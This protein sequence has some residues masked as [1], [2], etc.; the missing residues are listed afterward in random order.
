MRVAIIEN[1]RCIL[2][3]LEILLSDS[4]CNVVIFNHPRNAIS[5][6][7]R[8][9]VDVLIRDYLMPEFTGKELLEKVK[10]Y[11]S[12]SCRIIIVSGYMEQ[13]DQ[14]LL[15]QLG[16]VAFLPKPLDLDKLCQLIE[17]ERVV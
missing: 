14:E 10:E 3:S 8:H 16:V 5:Y 2:R 15:V 11:L 4:G 17:I 7:Q 9:S 6:L 1:D 13:V 12:H